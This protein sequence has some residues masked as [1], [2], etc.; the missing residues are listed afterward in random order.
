MKKRIC[1]LSFQQ[2]GNPILDTFS[3]EIL[4][5]IFKNELIFVTPPLTSGELTHLIADYNVALSVYKANGKNYKTAFLQARKKLLDAL[6][7]LATYV[8]GIADGDPSIINLAGFIPT[9]GESHYAPPLEKILVVKSK[10]TNV[11]GQV[12]IE[13]PP[14]VGKGVTGYTLILV[15][16]APLNVENFAADSL[17]FTAVE[18]QQII[19]SL[20]K[21][22]KKIINGLDSNLVYYAYMYAVNSTGVSP[23][24]DGVRVKCI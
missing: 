11:S 18:G 7:N 20:T 4:N 22:K 24:S 19:I 1:R 8:N 12:I 17:N 16:G 9:A 14:I 5:G 10:P 23:L 6:I 13:T 3:N 21:G 2:Y 15:S